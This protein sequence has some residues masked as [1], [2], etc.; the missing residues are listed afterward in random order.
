[1]RAIVTSAAVL[2]AACTFPD[3]D[4]A[5]AGGGTAGGGAAGGG[6]VD[7][8]GGGGS[9]ST[10]SSTSSSTSTSAGGTCP[11]PVSCA[12][13]A[14]SCA[15]DANDKHAGCVAG[16]NNDHACILACDK[17]QKTELGMCMAACD[18]CAA[19]TCGSS[20]TNCRKLVGL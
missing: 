20:T 15:K 17:V 2:F 10:S 13:D 19:P 9:A 11:V 12:T 8:A 1:M 7:A 16:C 4:Y 6:T 18:S 3:V 14:M 5:D